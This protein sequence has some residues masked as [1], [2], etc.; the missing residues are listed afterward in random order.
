[1]VKFFKDLVFKAYVIFLMA[2]TVWY[3]TF[4]YP[5]IFG[6]EG[7][8]EA[9]ASLKEMGHAGTEEEKLYVSL[10][11]SKEQTKKIVVGDRV[12]EQTYI[13]GR[14]HHTGFRMDEDKASTCVS[15]HGAVPHNKSKEM[16]SFLNMHTYYTACQTCHIHPE[17]G[18]D[19][20]AFGWYDISTGE[21]TVN[22]PSLVEIEDK[23]SHGE[24]DYYPIYGNYS[25]KIAPGKYTDNI[26][27]FIK[28]TSKELVA[29]YLKEVANMSPQK[30]SQMVEIIHK[31]M[32]KEPIV[33]SDCHNNKDP[34][35]PYAELGYP[36]RRVEELTNSEVVGMID[37]YKEFFQPNFVS[38]I[39]TDQSGG[40]VPNP[41]S[42]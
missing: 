16:R 23:F 7:K 11:A 25:A 42:D 24:K 40:G 14:F 22:P 27:S 12:I 36:P 38:P 4:M 30:K 9:E 28:G 2:F 31:G 10:I 35:L 29:S 32:S 26:F 39:G 37:K 13:E 5:L 1:M 34:Y 33:C 19:K 20:L 6:F 8:E 41:V 15:C 17:E 18:G 21:R 3:G